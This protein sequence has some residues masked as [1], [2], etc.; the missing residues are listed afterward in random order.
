[1]SCVRPSKF[2]H[3]VHRARRFAISNPGVLQP[4]GQETERQEPASPIRG[5]LGGEG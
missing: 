5:V 4:D 2:A 3:V 1:M